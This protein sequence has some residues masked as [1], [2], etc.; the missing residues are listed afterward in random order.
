M[1]IGV[2]LIHPI[3]GRLEGINSNLADRLVHFTEALSP[4]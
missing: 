4:A 3:E 2:C 1:E